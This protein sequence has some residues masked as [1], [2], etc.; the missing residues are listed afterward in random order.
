[1]T[2]FVFGLSFFYKVFFSEFFNFRNE[3]FLCFGVNGASFVFLGPVTAS[4][5]GCS[6]RSVES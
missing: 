5:S 6:G 4:D 1:M 3:E 2:W